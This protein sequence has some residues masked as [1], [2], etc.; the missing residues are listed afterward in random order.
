MAG[1][2]LVPELIGADFARSLAFYTALLGFAVRY[3]RPEGRCAYPERAGAELLIEQSV[4]R[5]SLAAP[6]EHP[7]GRGVNFQ[8]AV[9]DVAALH[10]WVGEAGCSLY[11]SLEE[12]WYRRGPRK[13]AI[14]DSSSPTE[15][16]ICCAS[17]GVLGVRSQ[18]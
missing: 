4:G 8:I 3:A 15:T 12:K 18:G 17:A 9:G 6:L 1:A 16:D 7:Y 11:L 2:R 10:A 14:A 5:T 13:S